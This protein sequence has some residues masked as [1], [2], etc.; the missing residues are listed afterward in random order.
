MELFYGQ[1]QDFPTWKFQVGRVYKME[2]LDVSLVTYA[3]PDDENRFRFNDIMVEGDTPVTDWYWSTFVKNRQEILISI[4]DLGA[5][6]EF[7]EY[8]L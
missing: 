1:L 4:T 8:F 3:I 7:P 6:E 2:Y 5:K